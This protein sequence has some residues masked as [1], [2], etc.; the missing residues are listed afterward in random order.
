M[1]KQSLDEADAYNQEASE[2]IR[3]LKEFVT[4]NFGGRCEDFE[5]RCTTCWLW[6][7]IDE[8]EGMVTF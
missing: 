8:I 7:Q 4:K 1:T 5:A 6:K 3:T 2:V